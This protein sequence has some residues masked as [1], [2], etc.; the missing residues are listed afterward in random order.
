MEILVRENK[1]FQDSELFFFE[2][3]FAISEHEQLEKARAFAI[4]AK[5]ESLFAVF[6]SS[7]EEF[8]YCCKS[9]SKLEDLER[10]RIA[11]RILY[12]IRCRDSG[13]Y[14]FVLCTNLI[15]KKEQFL[16]YVN[17][18]FQGKLTS[19]HL[20]ALIERKPIHLFRFNHEKYQVIGYTLNIGWDQEILTKPI[21]NRLIQ[22][23][24]RER[25]N[26]LFTSTRKAVPRVTAAKELFYKSSVIKRY[27]DVV[28]LS[29]FVV[30]TLELRRDSYVLLRDLRGEVFISFLNLDDEVFDIHLKVNST[31]YARRPLIDSSQ[32]PLVI[33]LKYASR[34][35]LFSVLEN[36]R[37]YEIDLEPEYFEGNVWYRI[38]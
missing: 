2:N 7:S 25:V 34:V 27:N 11:K 29:D 3:G 6:T 37:E 23:D 17:G 26:E 28:A 32:F 15:T 30:A 8:E 22:E 35:D 10:K 16:K 14:E 1:I 9:P 13:S 20:Q 33:Y 21:F 36:E 19:Q 4:S 5:E 31:R 38:G 12:F 18:I 24:I